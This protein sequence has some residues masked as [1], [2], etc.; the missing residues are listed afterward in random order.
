[1]RCDGSNFSLE[2]IQPFYKNCENTLSCELTD[3]HL[4]A[5]LLQNFSFSYSQNLFSTFFFNFLKTTMALVVC[6]QRNSCTHSSDVI[7]ADEQTA[8]KLTKTSASSTIFLSRFLLRLHH[9]LRLNA[10]GFKTAR[11]KWFNINSSD[12]FL[13]Y[14]LPSCGRT[15]GSAANTQVSDVGGFSSLWLNL[16]HNNTIQ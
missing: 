5:A 12:L 14:R 15:S 1:M 2:V 3:S 9:R 4:S 11:E 8:T 6:T 16:H 7:T 10:E 13:F